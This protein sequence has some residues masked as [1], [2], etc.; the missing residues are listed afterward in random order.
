MTIEELQ[1]RAAELRGAGHLAAQPDHGDPQE[2]LRC[3]WRAS[4]SRCSA[5][6]LGASNRKDG[7]LASFVARHRVIFAYYVIMFTAR[8]AD[9]G[10][11][12][13]GVAGDVAAEH[14]RSAPPA[15]L[16]LISRARSAD[17]PIRI[18]LPAL[19]A[20]AVRRRRHAPAT[21]AGVAPASRAAAGRSC[22]ACR[23]S[24]CRGRRCSTLYIAKQYLRILAH[25]HRR[26]AGPV[27]H[28]DVHR[29]VGQVVQGPDHARR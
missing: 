15:S 27:L 19:A 29:H 22:C 18:P 5:S 8:G 26:H 2:V 28:L 16:L 25:D 4:C 21:T 14:R 1:A 13:A 12:D 11:L 3:R 20:V 17:Q 6:A 24:S 9:Q 10:L 7:K 23:T